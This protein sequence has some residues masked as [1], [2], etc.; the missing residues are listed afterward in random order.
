MPH[1]LLERED[2]THKTNLQPAQ[3]DCDHVLRSQ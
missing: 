3:P 2:I 1:E